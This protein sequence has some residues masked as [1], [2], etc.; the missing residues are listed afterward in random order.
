MAAAARVGDRLSC[1]PANVISSGSPNV[2]FNNIAVGRIGDPTPGH[3]GGSPS[4]MKTGN[5]SSVYANNKSICI[6]G[7]IDNAHGGG[8]HVAATVTVGSPDVFIG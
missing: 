8:P 1:H 7:S 6:I 5:G 3:P 2:F 4:T